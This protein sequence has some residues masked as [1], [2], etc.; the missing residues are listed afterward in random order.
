MDVEELFHVEG[1]AV[2][3]PS[4]STTRHVFNKHWLNK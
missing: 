4:T 3:H 2:D 1:G